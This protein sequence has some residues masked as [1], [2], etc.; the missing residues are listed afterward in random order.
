MNVENKFSKNTMLVS[1]RIR[2]LNKKELQYSSL[3]TLQIENDK[4][5]I[6]SSQ[7]QNQ[8][9]RRVQRYY[10]CFWGYWI[11]KDLYYGWK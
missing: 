11:W 6:I 10:I 9:E 4:I 8:K 3:K 2:P 5:K 1:V 7:K